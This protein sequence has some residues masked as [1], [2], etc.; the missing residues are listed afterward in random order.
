MTTYNRKY[1][2]HRQVKKAGLNLKLEKCHKTIQVPP[3]EI[4]TAKEN[5]Y[6]SELRDKYSYGVQTIIE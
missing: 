6:I 3:G 4:P 2:L 1:Y 5:K